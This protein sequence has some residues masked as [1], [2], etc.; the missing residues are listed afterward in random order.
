[1]AIQDANK[2]ES[3]LWYVDT[4]YS[5]Q[6]CRNKSLFSSLNDDLCSMV[7]FSDRLIVKVMGEDDTKIKTRVVLLK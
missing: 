6:L 7:S 4:R 5:N 1:M 3:E 2:L